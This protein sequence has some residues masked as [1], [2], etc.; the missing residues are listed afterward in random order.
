MPSIASMRRSQML[1]ARGSRESRCDIAG[2]SSI[3]R[4]RAPPAEGV[5]ARERLIVASGPGPVDQC[6]VVARDAR[7]RTI[8]PSASAN[9]RAARSSCRPMV[10]DHPAHGG[11]KLGVGAIAQAAAAQEPGLVKGAAAF[12]DD[13]PA[14]PPRTPR[15][16]RS[17]TSRGR[18]TA[19]PPRGRCG[20]AG[21]AP[22]P[23]SSPSKCTFG[24]S[25]A[26]A[27][28]S[29]SYGPVPAIRRSTSG[30]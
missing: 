24:R 27:R 29:G 26:S 17:R 11:Q 8:R 10:V 22:R 25:R 4:A 30:R 9:P 21:P 20:R 7:S 3:G 6:E 15:A 14:S 5:R 28:S 13:R 12:V 18:A 16:P 2:S 1:S 19:P 23:P